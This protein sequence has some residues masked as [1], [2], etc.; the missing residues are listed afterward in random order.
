[1][2]SL[3]REWTVC[4]TLWPPPTTP[5]SGRWVSPPDIPWKQDSLKSY[6]PN[7]FLRSFQEQSETFMPRTLFWQPWCAA[8]GRITLGISLSKRLETSFSLTNVITP[9][10]VSSFP[11]FSVCLKNN[12]GLYR[13]LPSTQIFWRW[14]KLLPSLLRMMAT[15]SILPETWR[16]KRHLSITI[17]LSKFSK[18]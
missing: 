9:N 2:R 15:V 6:Q 18:L 3:Y 12:V 11:V 8:P 13:F 14:T 10:S 17:S 1:M 16:W 5:S 4:S 7:V